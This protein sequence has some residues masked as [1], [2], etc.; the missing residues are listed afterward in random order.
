MTY[1]SAVFSANHTSAF[2][3]SGVPHTFTV[4]PGATLQLAASDLQGQFYSTNAITLRVNGGTLAQ[5]TGVVNGL[6]KLILE[7]AKLTYAGY[8]VQTPYYAVS[9]ARLQRRRRVPR[10]ERLYPCE[11]RRQQRKP[12]APLLRHVRWET[13]RLLRGG[14]LREGNGR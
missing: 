1:G 14:N 5:T 3:L 7:N 9:A 2:G 8:A 4:H 13:L 6:G 10:H 11:R 12:C